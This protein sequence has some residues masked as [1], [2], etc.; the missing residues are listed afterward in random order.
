MDSAVKNTLLKDEEYINQK[1]K[2]NFSL[3]TLADII[4]EAGGV[5]DNRKVLVEKLLNDAPREKEHKPN[6][7]GCSGCTSAAVTEKRICRCM[8]YFMKEPE[9]CKACSLGVKWKNT[10]RIKIVDYERPTRYVMKNIG[11]MDLIINDSGQLYA[12]EVK[13]YSSTETLARMFAEILT[14]TVDL[15]TGDGAN[16]MKPAI[17]FF[18]GSEQMKQYMELMKYKNEA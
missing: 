2:L 18:E 14:Y 1:S 3:K 11:G 12:V 16:S 9:R 10:G 8:Y 17:C 15:D 6:H 13:P 5:G 4:K 7:N